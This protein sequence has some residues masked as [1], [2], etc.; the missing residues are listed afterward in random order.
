MKAI[1]LSFFYLALLTGA[2]AQILIGPEAGGNLSWTRF[3]DRDLRSQYKVTPI[4]GYSAG[5]HLGFRVQKRY[6][7]HLSLIYSTKGRLI[8]GK[9]TNV[10][11]HAEGL[12]DRVRLSYIEM[13][14]I[15]AI[16]F[17]GKLGGNKEFKYN[18]GAGPLVSYWLG[19]VGYASS[20]EIR[21]DVK[22]GLIDYHVAF[23][24]GNPSTSEMTVQSANRLQL[25]LNVAGSLIF[26]PIPSRR[27]MLTVRYEVGGT[28][29]TKNNNAGTF[30]GTFYQQPLQSRNKGLRVSV[31]YLFD[32][33]N[34][35]RKKG[36]SVSDKKKGKN[37][38]I[39]KRR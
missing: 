4:I 21:E 30:N 20:N 14:I 16:D 13:P 28:Y 32:L 19:G 33:K 3:D 25:G 5:A 39:R 2:S 31:A 17:K 35:Q 34:D 10:L 29:L 18:I 6:F 37:I 11:N 12:V 26:E 36:K 1:C 22:G 7:L 38:T 24:R 27:I 15:Y 9:T 8:E 23:K